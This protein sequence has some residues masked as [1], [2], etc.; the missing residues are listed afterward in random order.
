MTGLP[1]EIYA[2]SANPKG[3]CKWGGPPEFSDAD[4]KTVVV[5]TNGFAMLWFRASAS[6]FASLDYALGT[7]RL[8]GS[9]NRF[10][11]PNPEYNKIRSRVRERSGRG[12]DESVIQIITTYGGCRPLE[13]SLRF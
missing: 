7:S 12:F 8:L 9:L 4:R 6:A 1:P 10:S 11:A 3:Q 5:K 13:L 2:L